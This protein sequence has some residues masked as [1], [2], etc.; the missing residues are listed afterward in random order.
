MKRTMRRVALRTAGAI[1]LGFLCWAKANAVDVKGS[2]RSEE[3]PKQSS[4]EAVR[5]PYWHEWNGFIEPKKPSVD[6]AREVAVVLVGNEAMK[7]AVVVTLSNGTLTPSTIVAQHNAPLRFRNQDDFTHQLYSDNLK[8]FDAIET[9]SGQ[10]RELTLLQTGDF[11]I[12][13][14]LAPYVRGHLHVLPKVTAIAAP[15][16]D[17]SFVF[18]DVNP[19]N[20]TLKVFRGAFEMSSSALEVKDTREVVVGPISVDAKAKK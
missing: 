19:G 5:A 10:S 6:Y 12:G 7:D 20:Y 11:V 14:R 17:G 3:T 15:Q 1:G 4:I 18:K 9:S 8:E 13:D 2:V 16:S